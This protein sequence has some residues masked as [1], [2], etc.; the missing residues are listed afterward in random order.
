MLASQQPDLLTRL[1]EAAGQQAAADGEDEA[2]W[3]RFGKEV[4]ALLSAPLP[5]PSDRIPP[6]REWLAEWLAEEAQEC[7]EEEIGKVCELVESLPQLAALRK[8]CGGAP[9]P[10]GGK[11]KKQWGRLR[12]AAAKKLTECIALPRPLALTAPSAFQ[13]WLTELGLTDTQRAAVLGLARNVAELAALKPED[14]DSGLPVPRNSNPNHANPPDTPPQLGPT[15]DGPGADLRHWGV[16]ALLHQERKGVCSADNVALNDYDAKVDGGRFKPE[17]FGSAEFVR[18]WLCARGFDDNQVALVQSAAPDLASLI[19]LDDS[20][21]AAIA[22]QACAAP[23]PCA[24]PPS[25]AASVA[26][27]ISLAVSTTIRCPCVR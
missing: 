18:L 11:K 16:R 23:L 4:F 14:L 10:L 2:A 6:L 26:V 19:T 13:Y 25:C 1:R 15:R 9:N 20:K 22:L 21:L 27:C 5:Q 8:Q 12:E 3:A 24:A 17:S 7:N